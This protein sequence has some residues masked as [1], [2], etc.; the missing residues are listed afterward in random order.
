VGGARGAAD[1]LVVVGL[2]GGVG[3]VG[4]GI[5]AENAVL[6]EFFGEP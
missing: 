1:E 6:L 5:D 3:G 2:V 4:A